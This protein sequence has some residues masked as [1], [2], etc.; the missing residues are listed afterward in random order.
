MEREGVVLGGGDSGR[1]SR[2][3]VQAVTFSISHTC[4]CP[5]RLIIESAET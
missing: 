4:R 3:G 5:A 2:A 1:E